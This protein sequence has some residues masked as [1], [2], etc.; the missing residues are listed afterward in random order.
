MT[1]ASPPTSFLASGALANKAQL[2]ADIRTQ[3]RAKLPSYM[4]PAAIVPLAELPRTMNGKV[5]R[6]N[7]PLP[8]C[9]S[10]AKYVA[11]RDDIE[12]QLAAIWEEVLDRKSIGI[13]DNFFNTDGYSLTIVRLFTRINKAFRTSLPITTIFNAPT[14]AQ[15]ADVLRGRAI[16]SALVPVQTRGTKPPL[17]F[18]HSYLLYGKLPE[19]IGRDQPV[20]GLRELEDDGDISIPERAARYIT[21]MRKLQTHGPYYLAGWSAAGPIAVE[22][23]G[24]LSKA[25]EEVALTLL[26]DSIR[27]GYEEEMATANKRARTSLRM[28]PAIE[29][30]RFHARR[31]GKLSFKGKLAYLKDNLLHRLE[32]ARSNF[33][34]RRWEILQHLSKRF[35]FKL[36]D[37]LYNVSYRTFAALNSHRG[38]SIPNRITLIRAAESYNIPNSTDDW[39]WSQLTTAGVD[40]FFAPGTHETMFREPYLSITATIVRESIERGGAALEERSAGDLGCCI[41]IGRR[42]CRGDR[43]LDR[44]RL[45]GRRR[46][47]Q[48]TLA[49]LG[50]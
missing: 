34:T 17:F 42:S 38:D 39:G 19:A 25:G 6:R 11:P 5:D 48:S 27:P 40:V 15:L 18:L 22:A 31:L 20:Y 32:V 23:S 2:I 46:W 33:F 45:S 12:R 35:G 29:K 41:G 49:L 37:F 43:S 10:S 4:Q 50:L 47:R 44:G 36:P 1:S 9:E 7:L 14:I 21:E 30:L 3:L 28:H 13:E 16:Y 8:Q 26:F 24:Q